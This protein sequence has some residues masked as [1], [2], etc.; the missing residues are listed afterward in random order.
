[1]AIIVITDEHKQ[2]VSAIERAIDA[3]VV[4]DWTYEGREFTTTDRH[5]AKARLRPFNDEGA[6]VF[7]AIPAAGVPLTSFAYA[8]LHASFLQLLLEHADQL[9]DSVEITAQMS[10]WDYAVDE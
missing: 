8:R 6:V 9:F 1:M 3:G 5:G 4:D 2:V 10:E 7:G